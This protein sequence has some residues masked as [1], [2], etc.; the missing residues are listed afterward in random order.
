[1]HSSAKNKIVGGIAFALCLAAYLEA[2][3]A[4]MAADARADVAAKIARILLS[5]AANPN[6]A[7]S[8]D[9]TPLIMAT[10]KGRADLVGIFLEHGADP[11]VKAGTN[12]SPLAAARKLGR[13]DIRRLLLDRVTGEGQMTAAAYAAVDRFFDLPPL[14]HTLTT[15]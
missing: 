12:D 11:N 14:V 9:W 1:M 4:I 7:D 13:D 5:R 8:I 10:S 6:V 3:L 15:V 2:D